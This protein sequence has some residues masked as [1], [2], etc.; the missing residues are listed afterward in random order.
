MTKK[1]TTLSY[2]LEFLVLIVMCLVERQ[3][4]AR[5]ISRKKFKNFDFVSKYWLIDFLKQIVSLFLG[6]LVRII[7]VHMFSTEVRMFCSLFYL[8]LHFF[9]IYFR[10]DNFPLDC[11]FLFVKKTQETIVNFK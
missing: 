10:T 5:G 6:D 4:E 11:L 3:A 1:Y 7:Y 8:F 2:I 9:K